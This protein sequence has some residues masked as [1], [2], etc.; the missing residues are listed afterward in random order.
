MGDPLAGA[1]TNI[2]RARCDARPECLRHRCEE[3][4]AGD[5]R[6]Q[7]HGAAG[8]DSG[9]RLPQSARR[10][11]RLEPTAGLEPATCYLRMSPNPSLL[12]R[13]S[14]VPLASGLTRWGLNL[15][16]LPTVK[17]ALKHRADLVVVLL[18][19]ESAAKR[20]PSAVDGPGLGRAAYAGASCFVG[21]CS[22]MRI[23]QHN[24]VHTAHRC[25]LRPFDRGGPGRFH[26]A[27][28]KRR[29]ERVDER[30]D[31]VDDVYRIGDHV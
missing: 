12:A 2:R 17:L 27:F 1:D 23:A 9:A 5:L 7:D 19:A 31:F 4:E 14:T 3:R 28:C 21:G 20:A 18:D 25:A 22:S 8:F 29:I 13:A 6:R 30:E 10:A 11:K 26:E 15:E 24:T 16:V